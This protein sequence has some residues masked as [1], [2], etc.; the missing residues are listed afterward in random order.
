MM[1]RDSP[2]K[3]KHS[4]NAGYPCE[5]DAVQELAEL[6]SE[7]FKDEVRMKAHQAN[8]D[9]AHQQYA[10]LKASYN[11]LYSHYINIKRRESET[12]QETRRRLEEWRK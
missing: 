12:L 4:T 8:L 5:F 10:N 1:H 7:Q 9:I 11:D 2:Q 6:H 3:D